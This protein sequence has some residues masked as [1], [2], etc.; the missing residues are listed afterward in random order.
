VDLKIGR[1]GTA[2]AVARGVFGFDFAPGGAEVWYRTSC[3]RNAEACDLWAAPLAEPARTRKIADGVKSFEFN[4][5]RAGRVLL[6]WARQDRVA[7]DL[8]VWDE[9]RL[10]AVDKSAV[11][12]TAVFLA[13]DSRRLAYAVNDPKRQGLYLAEIP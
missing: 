5:R 9:G 8:A 2:T 11:P 4:R 10:T 13:P 6:G 1:G 7:L 12:G 3:A